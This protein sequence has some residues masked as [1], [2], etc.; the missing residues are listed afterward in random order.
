MQKA[1]IGSTEE[2]RLPNLK[3]G[4]SEIIVKLTIPSKRH[5]LLRSP[6]KLS[7]FLSLLVEPYSPGVI[8]SQ[9]ASSSGWTKHSW[10]IPFVCPQ[11]NVLLELF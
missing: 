4:I 9:T 8:G 11:H 10:S 5:R 3:Y 2:A 7:S 6:Q 1:I